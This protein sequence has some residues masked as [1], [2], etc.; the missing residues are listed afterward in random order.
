[1]RPDRSLGHFTMSENLNLAM[2]PPGTARNRAWHFRILA[3][4]KMDFSLTR[5]A[6]KPT[7]HRAD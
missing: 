4:E 1:M 5:R 7:M 6:V 2:N 3:I